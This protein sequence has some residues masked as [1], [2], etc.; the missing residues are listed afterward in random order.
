MPPVVDWVLR[1]QQ[2]QQQQAAVQSYLEVFAMSLAAIIEM[3]CSN[4]PSC[5]LLILLLLLLLLLLI[6]LLLLLL[7]LLLLLLLV[8]CAGMNLLL[9]SCGLVGGVGLV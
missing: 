9:G 5:V 4:R 2:Q 3:W 1:Q 8:F 7:I 6:L